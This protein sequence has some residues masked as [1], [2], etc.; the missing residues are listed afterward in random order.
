VN[1]QSDV[2]KMSN[3]L[4]MQSTYKENQ[5]FVHH[6]QSQAPLHNVETIVEKAN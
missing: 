2:Q 6:T 3:V 5:M 1:L 4:F